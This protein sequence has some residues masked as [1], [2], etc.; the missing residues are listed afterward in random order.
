MSRTLIFALTLLLI[1]A[2]ARGF[3]GAG[4]A[5]LLYESSRAANFAFALSSTTLQT[6]PANWLET[7]F[8]LP[9]FFIETVRLL[10]GNGVLSALLFLGIAALIFGAVWF[11]IA[12][13]FSRRAP[14]LPL[15]LLI[16]L[17]LGGAALLMRRVLAPPVS[18]STPYTIFAVARGEN[19]NG[20]I[21]R[22]E[23]SGVT[24][25]ALAGK[26]PLSESELAALRK[27]HPRVLLTNGFISQ[28][29]DGARFVAVGIAAPSAS[30][31]AAWRD[32]ESVARDIEKRGGAM[33]VEE[34]D[35]REY[36]RAPQTAL[37]ALRDESALK[38]WNARGGKNAI[39]AK[40]AFGATWTIL[41]RG[42]RDGQNV[43][44]AL[45]LGK[46]GAL[47]A[48]DFSA[49]RGF[50]SLWQAKRTA[51]DLTS[52]AGK[53]AI[54]LGVLAML[55]AVW[56]WSA[57]GAMRREES[58][59]G[60]QRAVGYLRKRRLLVRGGGALVLAAALGGSALVAIFAL[61]FLPALACWL[62][63][64]GLFFYGYRLWR[65]AP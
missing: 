24:A 58:L 42:L 64:N 21:A 6:R 3:F 63:L 26:E 52:R 34:N 8:A 2:T 29:S 60:P 25:A 16:A 65:Y 28:S 15:L 18:L 55:C 39:V 27:S 12:A 22:L 23:K 1:I 53:I 20:E 37:V 44:R 50:F 35:A 59:S 57:G 46:T 48:R 40:G 38:G 61:D 4:G 11:G 31:R 56:L 41:P 5:R 62:L 32:L 43:T 49:P 14:F 33:I 7:L 10:A 54:F 17:Q 47:F 13:F 51:W 30:T 36:S 19:L 9:L 45:R